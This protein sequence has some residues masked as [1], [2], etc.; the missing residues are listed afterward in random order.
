MPSCA[1]C[2][3]CVA[4]SMY[5]TADQPGYH[6]AFSILGRFSAMQPPLF[7]VCCCYGATAAV[8]L[9]MAPLMVCSS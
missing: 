9:Q 7:P 4:L 8:L 6:V 2:V 5:M 1:A 3:A